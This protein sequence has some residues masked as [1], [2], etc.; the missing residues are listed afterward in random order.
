VRNRSFIAVTAFLAALLVIAGAVYAYDSG[1]ED[2]IAE[3]ISVGGIDVGGM[4]R[5]A[6]AGRL[7]RALLGPLREPI[8]VNHGKRQ[9]K[10]GPREAR[11]SADI[12]AMVDDA[13][14]RGRSGG[15]ISRTWRELTGGRVEADL[16]PQVGYSKDA[17]VR[18]IDRVRR[19]LERTP[20]DASVKFSAGGVARVAGK[21][22]RRVEAGALHRSIRAAIVS[23]SA[24]RTFVARTRK[25]RPKV[26]TD[27][28]EDRYP[29]VLI[30]NRSAF[31]LTLYKRLA[32]ARTYP[33]AVGKAG[34]ETPA[35]LY[36][37]A[38]KAINPA[39]HVPD[40]DWAGKLRGKVI[41]GGV[42]ENPI[43]S[44]W[45]GV[46]DGVGVHGT[47]DDASIGTT[48]SHGCI[49]MHIPDIEALYPEVPVGAPIYIA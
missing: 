33:I 30:V 6:A 19:K 25:V 14:A 39:W 46:Y 36:N 20:K 40:S 48:A 24:T 21:N 11:I 8:V 3:G 35:G 31:R 44:R 5:D 23:P 38:N 42:P 1:R 4:S 29:A 7:E 13:V 49:R 34:L 43:K 18:L 9:W 41:P 47:S 45:L 22:G 32:Q 10:L 28:L 17:V 2:R 16:T 15:V 26:T 12:A 37:I 27:D